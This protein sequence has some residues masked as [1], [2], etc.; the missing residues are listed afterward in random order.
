MLEIN[1]YNMKK[2]YLKTVIYLMIEKNEVLQVLNFIK[3][4]I[5]NQNICCGDRIYK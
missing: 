3:S 5:F 2:K 1:T 4:L